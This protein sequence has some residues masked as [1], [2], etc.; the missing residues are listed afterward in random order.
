M[1]LI[2]THAILCALRDPTRWVIL[3][4]KKQEYN[5]DY[6][7]RNKEQIR[8]YKRNYKRTMFGKVRSRIYV[9]NAKARRTGHSPV[10]SSI[11]RVMAIYATQVECQGCGRSDTKLFIDHC[12]VTGKVRGMLCNSCNRLDVLDK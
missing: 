11:Y 1:F 12:H 5:K 6:F 3:T 2:N 10:T 7:Q 8:E 9:T 4:M